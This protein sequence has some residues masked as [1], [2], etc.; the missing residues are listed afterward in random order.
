MSKLE[1]FMMGCLI[2]GF[3]CG[4]FACALPLAMIQGG[5]FFLIEIIS[6]F[7]ALYIGYRLNPI[8]EDIENGNL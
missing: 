7:M 1:K 6:A 2:A 5:I 8:K 3:F 4:I